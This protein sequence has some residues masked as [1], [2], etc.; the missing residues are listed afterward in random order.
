MRLTK[1]T[2]KRENCQ[3]YQAKFYLNFDENR[4]YLRRRNGGRGLKSIKITYKTRV[5][6]ARQHFR[7][8]QSRNNNLESVKNM[9][10][11]N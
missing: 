3:L 2:F 1:L 7:T 6:A 9:K 10:V 5:I 11:K 8:N 4:L